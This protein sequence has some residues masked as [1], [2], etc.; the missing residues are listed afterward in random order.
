MGLTPLMIF[1]IC[2]TVVR[3]LRILDAFAAQAERR[4]RT[5]RRRASTEDPP[6]SSH[7]HRGSHRLDHGELAAL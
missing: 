5:S 7:D 4:S 2:T 1:F 3:A 6:L